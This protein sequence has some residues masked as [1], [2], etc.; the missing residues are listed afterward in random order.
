MRPH[1]KSRETS[2]SSDLE[3]NFHSLTTKL[4]REVK[5]KAVHSNVNSTGTNHDILSFIRKQ[6]SRIPTLFW[7]EVMKRYVI[8]EKRRT[9]KEPE[10]SVFRFTAAIQSDIQVHKDPVKEYH[11][12]I[13]SSIQ[14]MIVPFSVKEAVCRECLA[15][16][17]KWLSIRSYIVFYASRVESAEMIVF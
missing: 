7:N 12:F 1:W 11:Q 16:H 3:E 2:K 6:T 14:C 8:S 9:A 10:V 17:N 13:L 15:M 5:M 4:C